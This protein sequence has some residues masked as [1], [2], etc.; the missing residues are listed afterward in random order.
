MHEKTKQLHF[1]KL[2]VTL[3]SIKQI[4][5]EFSITF[6]GYR[7]GFVEHLRPT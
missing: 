6:K 1:S 7:V 2:K 3:N 4:V 5:S